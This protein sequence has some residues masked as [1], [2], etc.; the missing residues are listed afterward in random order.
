MYKNTVFLH[1]MDNTKMLMFA[2]NQ[3]SGVNFQKEDKSSDI[4]QQPPF[5]DRKQSNTTNHG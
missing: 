1:I 4:E 2:H 3:L 5:G